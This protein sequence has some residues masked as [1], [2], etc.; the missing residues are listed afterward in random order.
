MIMFPISS[1]VVLS[2]KNWERRK[3]DRVIR[4]YYD[5][6][7]GGSWLADDAHS[8]LSVH[9]STQFMSVLEQRFPLLSFDS[10]QFNKNDRTAQKGLLWDKQCG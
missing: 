6:G 2:D 7:S 9:E 5:P 1:L 10:L 3:S 8:R 4:Y